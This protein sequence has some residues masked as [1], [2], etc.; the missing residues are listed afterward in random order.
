MKK[1]TITNAIILAISFIALL[2]LEN[3][4]DEKVTII[5]SESVTTPDNFF[6]NGKYIAMN[7]DGTPSYTVVSPSMKQYFDTEMIQLA[8]PKIL[9]FRNKK[10]PTQIVSGFGRVSYKTKNIKLNDKVEMQ[11][12]EKEDA[13][14]L[15]LTTGEIYIYLNEQLAVTEKNV[16]IK[17][18]ISF[19]S[20]KGMKSSLLKG[21]FVLFEDTK[22]KYIE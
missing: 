20:G 7:E 1:A 19:L 8:S 4:Y 18:N 2:M 13:S 14:K 17:K 10:P 3:F 15:I 5:S 16:L 6:K 11:F 22:G 9:L 21:E 12:K